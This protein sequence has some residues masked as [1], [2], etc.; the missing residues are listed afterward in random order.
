MTEHEDKLIKHAT[1]GD[2]KAQYALAKHYEIGFRLGFDFSSIDGIVP[3]VYWYFKAAEQGYDEAQYTL[4]WYYLRGIG[5][6]KD[7]KQS[8]YWFRKAA[9]QGHT[10]ARRR[11]V[12]YD[13][14]I[15]RVD[16]KDNS[17]KS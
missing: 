11:I 17:N 15:S 14:K 1:T 12:S 13:K 8:I 2:K 4:G 10:R 9:E 16:S 6:E 3:D 5:V 7:S